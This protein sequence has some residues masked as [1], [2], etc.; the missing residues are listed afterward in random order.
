M[1]MINDG[2]PAF[3]IHPGAA[4]DGQLVRETQGMTLRDYF[5]AKAMQ[6]IIS[7]GSNYAYTK[8]D[9]DSGTPADAIARYSYQVAD[10]MLKVREGE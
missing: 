7:L 5:A 2:G 4:M 1:N 8:E 6:G 9:M 10:A 3:P